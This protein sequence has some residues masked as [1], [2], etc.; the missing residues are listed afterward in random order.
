MRCTAPGAAAEADEKVITHPL[1][2]Q[3]RAERRT[4]RGAGSTGVRKLIARAEAVYE[5]LRPMEGRVL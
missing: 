3:S 1:G 4:K 2:C 5:S